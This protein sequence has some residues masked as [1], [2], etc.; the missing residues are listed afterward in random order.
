MI[1]SSI[2][3][4]H[5]P[6]PEIAALL[7]CIEKSYIDIVYI[8]D[9][10][11]N[12]YF[13]CLEKQSN[14]IRYIY[15]KNSGYGASHNIALR[16]ALDGGAEFHLVLNP[17]IRFTPETIPALMAYMRAHDDVAYMLPKVTYPDGS[18]QYLCKL[19][20]TPFD[21]FFRR[22]IPN[23]KLT[24]KLNDNYV[25]RNSGYNQII[26]TPCLSGCFMFLRASAIKEHNLFFDERFFMYCED[27]DFIRRL[28]RAAKTIYYPEV[29]IIHAHTKESYT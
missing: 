13:R 16:E 10:S 26:N 5:T 15:N 7:N 1:T 3:L 23:T 21:L 17:D 19:L 27:V 14:K 11:S 2:V 22:F 20:P 4:Y 25:L 8:I 18:L 29:S 12:D 28:H 9:N 24:R 6:K